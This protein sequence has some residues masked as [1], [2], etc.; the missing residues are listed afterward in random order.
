[1]AE[2]RLSVAKRIADLIGDHVLVLEDALTGWPAHVRLLVQDAWVPVSLYAAPVTKSNRHRDDAERR[3]QNPGSD[4]PIVVELGRRALLLGLWEQDELVGVPSPVLVAADSGRRSGRATRVSIFVSLR[5]LQVAA[6]TGLAAHTSDANETFYAFQPQ[7]LPLVAAAVWSGTMLPVQEIQ[8]AATLGRPDQ[9]TKSSADLGRRGLRIPREQ[10]SAR[11]RPTQEVQQP[12]TLAPPIEE[13]PEPVTREQVM[14]QMREQGA[15]LKAIGA[16]F[17]VTRE[18]VRQI[19]QNAG[20]PNRTAILAARAARAHEQEFERQAQVDEVLRPLLQANGAMSIQEASSALGIDERVLMDYWPHGLNHLRIW[21]PG[22]ADQ[23][24]TDD[25]ILAAVREAALYGFPLTAN[26][27]SELIRVGQ[28]RGPSLPRVHQR[29]GGWAAACEAAGVEHGQSARVS[30]ESRWT[31]DE[32]LAY[33]RDYFLDFDWP[34]SAH[35]F[36]DWRREKVPDA[37]SV[38]TLRN[39]FGTWANLKRLALRPGEATNG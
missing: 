17:G 34:S 12:P 21:T 25:E 27:Y 20:G 1:M 5:A 10:A 36:D 11:P 16:E 33:A 18:R 7:F 30:Y 23:T 35:R 14:V 28:V 6:L 8:A 2:R 39:R 22:R 3:F 24:W 38:G 4:R 19:I 9:E 26:D 37:P 15:T 31:D 32:L 29:F 13:L